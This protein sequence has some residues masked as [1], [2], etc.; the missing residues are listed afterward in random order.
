[1]AEPPGWYILC[2][3]KALRR[4]PVAVRIG[5][6]RLVAFRTAHGEADVLDDRC[7]HRGMPLS[8]GSVTGDHLKCPYHGW[9]YGCD[10]GVR[11]VPALAHCPQSRAD[12]KVG[13]LE[14]HADQVSGDGRCLPGKLPRL[15]AREARP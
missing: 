5:E 8:A 13:A 14:C 2:R 1:M 6:R 10:G 9:E 11:L 7:A 12:V 3:G 15:P 4:K